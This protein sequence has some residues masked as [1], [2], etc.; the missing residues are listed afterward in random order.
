MEGFRLSEQYS[1]ALAMVFITFT[2]LSAIPILMPFLAI[3]AY[4]HCPC[5][6][7][8][9]AHARACLQGACVVLL[10]TRL[11]VLWGGGTP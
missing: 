10:R 8:H 2:Y 5:T 1:E 4:G 6:H 7:A 11:C 3:C 9:A